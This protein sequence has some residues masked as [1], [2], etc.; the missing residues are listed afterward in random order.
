MKELLLFQAGNIQFGLNLPLVKSIQGVNARFAEQAG[1]SHKLV[2]VMDG[3]ELPLYDLPSILRDKTTSDEPMSQKVILV[4]A[5]EHPIALGVDR[6][7]QVVSV[8]SDHI[9]PL[10]RIFNGSS[11]S[12]FP[13]VLKH[14]DALILLLNPEEIENLVPKILITETDTPKPDAIKSSSEAKETP[15]HMAQDTLD[16]NDVSQD[17]SSKSDICNAVPAFGIPYSESIPPGEIERDP[18]DSDDYLIETFDLDTVFEKQ[19]PSGL[20]KKE[21]A[22]REELLQKEPFQPEENIPSDEQ[23]QVEPE[24]SAL[25]ASLED[26]TPDTEDNDAHDTE[27]KAAIADVVETATEISNESIQPE[28]STPSDEQKHAEPEPSALDTSLEDM[29][30]DTKGSDAHDTEEKSTVAN[31]DN[32]AIET[33]PDED[34]V[35]TGLEGRH[36]E[37]AS[38]N[39]ATKS[40]DELPAETQSEEEKNEVDEESLLISSI[41][42]KLD[43]MDEFNLPI[44]EEK[45][46]AGD[47]LS[48]VAASQPEELVSLKEA[49]NTV[50]PQEP[51]STDPFRSVKVDKDMPLLP[52]G[53]VPYLFAAVSTESE[54]IP[55]EPAEKASLKEAEVMVETLEEVSADP[56]RSAKEDE[57]EPLLP[58]GNVPYLF[59]AISTE[60]EPIPTEPAEEVSLKEA[61]AEVEVSESESPDHLESAEEDTATL[62]MPVNE[63]PFLLDDASI[64][65]EQIINEPSHAILLDSSDIVTPSSGNR[66]EKI[67]APSVLPQELGIDHGKQKASYRR[68]VT[69]GVLALLAILLLSIW[70]W[71]KN[72]LRLQKVV[73]KPIPMVYAAKEVRE[74]PKEQAQTPQ[75]IETENEGVLQTPPPLNTGEKTINTAHTSEQ[76]AEEILKIETIDFTLTV[77]RPTAT[78]KNGREPAS[79]NK[80]GKNEHSHIV[81]K[82]DT[83]WQIAERYLDDPYRYPELAERSRISNPDR[84]YPGDVV[85]IIKKN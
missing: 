35:E 80:T 5:H 9:H 61:E 52:I 48:Q 47:V 14:E 53:E 85:R 39:P 46:V 74:N 41:G 29:T 50:E 56:F 65:S 81:V 7:K 69:A 38:V 78:Q 12:C 27:E 45:P 13:Q 24:L 70:F 37:I 72:S 42:I 19:T 22:V 8:S 36:F 64:E 49:E 82:N 66:T 18:S 25:D 75:K 15:G 23:E 31:V 30:P 20:A 17:N 1:R 83:L 4:E 55:T 62:L 57:D 3:E 51:E 44:E 71:P 84:I 63:G 34:K 16:N 58:V 60:S 21:Q 6:V 43:S 54:P 79:V 68:P 73:R 76:S 40:Y 59:A 67:L 77:E 33:S 11:L 26:M 2:Q 10:P 32:I 28:E